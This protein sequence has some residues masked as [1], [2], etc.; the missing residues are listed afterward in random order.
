[1]G[2]RKRCVGACENI[3]RKLYVIVLCIASGV[4]ATAMKR[5]IYIQIPE[6]CDEN[7]DN[8]TAVEQGRYCQSCCKEVI[9]FSLMSDQEIINFLSK[10]RG[11]T[12]GNFATDQ[13][14]RVI[15]ESSSPSKRK[16]WAMMLSFMITLFISQRSSAQRG[17]LSISNRQKNPVKCATQIKGDTIAKITETITVEGKIIDSLL[18]PVPFATVTVAGSNVYAV[19]DSAGYYSL[20]NIPPG[21][22]T[23][24]VSSVGYKRKQENISAG[25][26]TAVKNILLETDTVNLP[27][28]VVT[29]LPLISCHRIEKNIVLEPEVKPLQDV[30]VENNYQRRM[31]GAYAVCTTRRANK[32]VIDSIVNVF[33]PAVINVFPNPVPAGG[34]VFVQLLVP[35]DYQLRLFNS[36]SQ[37]VHQTS[38]S[39]VTKKQSFQ[40]ELPLSV[41]PGIYFINV[42]DAKT[43]KQYTHKLII[44]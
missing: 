40:L 20:K 19:A 24:S 23:L 2:D 13:L 9:D 16:W 43:K 31:G 5:A 26:N 7:W 39:I 34:H 29:S 4:K 36:Q 27:G 10:P 33:K 6:P 8:M 25:Q 1:L 37:L 11:K 14:N 17:R 28:V 3:F 18:N 21:D 41:A 38:F 32:T 42:V 44:Q 30:V 15:T 35:S 12:C 22:I